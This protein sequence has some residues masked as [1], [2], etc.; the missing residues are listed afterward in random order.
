M[1]ELLLLAI[2]KDDAAKAIEVL[3]TFPEASNAS[4]IGKVTTSISTKSYF[5]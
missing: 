1:K 2:K 4:I 5:K 3:H